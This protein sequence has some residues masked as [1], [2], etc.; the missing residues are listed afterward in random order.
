MERGFGKE[1]A[2]IEPYKPYIEGLLRNEPWRAGPGDTTSLCPGT[3]SYDGSRFWLC[4]CGRIGMGPTTQH[5]ALKAKEP[6]V[7]ALFRRIARALK[8]ATVVA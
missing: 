8:T 2:V 3:L 1:H 5:F 7:V 6:E 4:S